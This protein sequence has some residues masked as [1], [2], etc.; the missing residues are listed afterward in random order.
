MNCD[1]GCG[2]IAAHQ[3][4]NG[5]MC[6]QE[7]HAKCPENRKRY[8]SPGKKNPMYG[9]KHKNSSKKL[10]SEKRKGITYSDEYKKKMSLKLKGKIFTEETKQK[11]TNALKGRPLSEETKKKISNAQT[12][13]LKDYQTKHPFLCKIEEFIENDKGQLLARCK[14]HKCKNS[15]EED[16]WFKPTK[17]QIHG[18]I[19]GIYHGNDGS[20]LYCSDKCKQECPLYRSRTDVLSTP[21]EKPHTDQEYRIWREVILKRD[22]NICQICHKSAEHVHHIEPQKLHPLLSLDPDNGLSVCKECHFKYG[23]QDECST[24]QLAK[25]VCQ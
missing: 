25:A 21:K 22:N 17:G 1:Y 2:N 7:H 4:N 9:R 10:M 8:G 6:C 20:Y 14:N 11:I 12:Y 19:A 16:G 15:K 5:K 18:R 13:K 3:L 24:G 23:H